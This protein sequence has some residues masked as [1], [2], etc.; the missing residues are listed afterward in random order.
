M[1]L[2]MA[3]KLTEHEKTV[4]NMGQRKALQCACLPGGWPG[5]GSPASCLPGAATGGS[6]DMH[7]CV[8]WE[9][10]RVVY[11]GSM[12]LVARQVR[13]AETQRGESWPN[14]LNVHLPGFV[15]VGRS[16]DLKSWS[17]QNNDLL[18]VILVAT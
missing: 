13:T 14:E 7:C 11:S 2:S 1:A 6:H 17:S 15:V 9:L 10:W 3:N 5:H 8:V 16:R 4:S 18:K 12:V